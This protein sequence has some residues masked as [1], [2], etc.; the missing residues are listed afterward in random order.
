MEKGAY[1]G[2]KEEF[3]RGMSKVQLGVGM[4]M[5]MGMEGQNWHW[6]PPNC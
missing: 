6:V 2:N 5:Q 3:E 4:K 1:G